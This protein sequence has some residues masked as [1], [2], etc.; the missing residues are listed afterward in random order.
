[1][2]DHRL[3]TRANPQRPILFRRVTRPWIVGML[4]GTAASATSVALDTGPLF[5]PVAASPETQLPQQ[6]SQPLRSYRIPGISPPVDESEA[7]VR[8]FVKQVSS[9]PRSSAWLMPERLIRSFVEAVVD[10][11]DGRTPANRLP[12]LRLSSRFRVV[13]Q[14]PNLYINSRSYER[15]NALAAATASIDA[16]GSARLYALLKPRI[17]G[18]YRDLGFA[19][20]SFDRTL[21]YAIV[22]VLATPVLDAPVR[23][24]PRRRG[25]AFGVSEL[26]ALPAAQRQLLRAGPRNVRIIQSSLRAI[27]QA[28]GIPAQRLPAPR[29]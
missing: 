22:M 23:V 29:S 2:E 19:D 4:I 26:E 18:A 8:D 20:R 10:V 14:G 12:L 11:A 16:D 21:E 3:G 6:G 5:A 15:F 7:A 28:L 13:E 1:M 24:E 25:Y 9:H 17:E 27:A